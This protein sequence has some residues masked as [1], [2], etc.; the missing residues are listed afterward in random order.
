[1]SQVAEAVIILQ[2]YL[3]RGLFNLTFSVGI[4]RVSPWPGDQGANTWR[5]SEQGKMELKPPSKL[6]ENVVFFFYKNGN[7]KL[8]YLEKCVYYTLSCNIMSLGR[9]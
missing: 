7:K 4:T 5:M 6:T 2:F 1:M 3:H 8:I 9:G